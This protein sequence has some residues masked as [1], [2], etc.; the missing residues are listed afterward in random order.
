[1]LTKQMPKDAALDAEAKEAIARVPTLWIEF[2]TKSASEMMD[3]DANAPFTKTAVYDAL[4]DVIG[5][6]N[7]DHKLDAA[8][9]G[10]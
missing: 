1:M 2:V 3:D 4:R 7:W 6:A 5:F 8:T 10:T 9:V